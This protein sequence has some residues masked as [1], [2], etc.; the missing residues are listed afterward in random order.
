MRKWQIALLA[1][2][3]IATGFFVRANQGARH[4]FDF[5]RKVKITATTPQKTGDDEGR[6]QASRTFR[7]SEPVRENVTPAALKNGAERTELLEAVE[8]IAFARK[9]GIDQAA[10]LDDMQVLA[11]YGNSALATIADELKTGNAD[12]GDD[13]AI[14]RRLGFIDVLGVSA[15]SNNVG[16]ALLKDFATSRID[17]SKSPRLMHMDL[18]DRM[19]AFSLW[20]KWDGDNAVEFIKT[21]SNKQLKREYIYQ[22]VTGFR[23]AGMTDEDAA[24][25]AYQVFGGDDLGLP[26]DQQKGDNKNG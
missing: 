4:S 23:L 14:E 21:V 24:E 15:A 11:K 8:R 20:A 5:A 13:D 26:L 2:S 22:L 19:E 7:T 18:V 12:E 17:P 9:H 3:V 6:L 1:F 10:A 16:R 25:K